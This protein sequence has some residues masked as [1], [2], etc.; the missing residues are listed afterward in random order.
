MKTLFDCET[1]EDVVSLVESGADVNERA[2][3]GDSPI[4]RAVN[5]RSSECKADVIKALIEHGANVNAKGFN[6]YT[7]LMIA[8]INDNINVVQ[9]LLE[10]GANVN[11]ARADGWTALRYAIANEYNDIAR[12]LN[13]RV[14]KKTKQ[15][16][17]NQ[18][19]KQNSALVNFQ[20]VQ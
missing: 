4:H 11:I 13:E 1:E 3:G 10:A 12:L 7:P 18:R 15:S 16:V 17:D 20:C 14:E 5:K 6:E 9:I 2:W 8:T 19:C